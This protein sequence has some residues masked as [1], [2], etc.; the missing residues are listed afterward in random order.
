M[1]LYLISLEM[2]VITVGYLFTKNSQMAKNMVTL[3]EYL[4]RV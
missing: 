1:V 2:Q 4:L 3:T